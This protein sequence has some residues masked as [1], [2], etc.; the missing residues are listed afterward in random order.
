MNIVLLRGTLSSAPRICDLPS[1][2]SLIAY[3]VSTRSAGRPTSSVP[4]VWFDPP[5]SR[6]EVAAGDE[7]IV[8]GEVKRRF[9]RT[10]GVTQARVEVVASQ[11]IPV[12]RAMQARRAV[13]GVVESLRQVSDSWL[14]LR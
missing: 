11:V 9:F 2:S 1:G 12:R 10:G 7:V 5:R 4:V 6:G 14:P 8:A 13:D 3:Q